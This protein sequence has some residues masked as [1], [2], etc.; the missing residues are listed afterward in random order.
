MLTLQS[1]ID[2]EFKNSL[3][4]TGFKL[5]FLLYLNDKLI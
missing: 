3:M 1:W 2:D 4:G 5:K